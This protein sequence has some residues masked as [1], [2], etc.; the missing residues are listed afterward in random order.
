MNEYKVDKVELP[1]M[2][3][4]ADGVVHEGVMFLSP[5]SPIH[6]G[7]QRL[8]DLLQE[9]FAFFPFRGKNGQFRLI[10]KNAIS[11]ARYPVQE[12]VDQ[13][14][15]EVKIRLT[16]FGG[17]ILDGSIYIAMPA[18][19]GRAQDYLNS[20]PGFF[21]MQSED[22]HYVVNDKLIQELFLLD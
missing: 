5:F 8:V 18:G 9:P 14:G 17:E 16:F 22:A 1:V 11:H 10:N 13:I 6:S 2:L 20:I 7:P 15:N 21:C 4:L 12:E 3:F 19:K